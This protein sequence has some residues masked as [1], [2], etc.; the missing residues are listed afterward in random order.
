MIKNN[1]ENKRSGKMKLKVVEA[2]NEVQ[3][4]FA[5]VMKM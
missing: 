1:T 5:N 2:L 4:S 3:E